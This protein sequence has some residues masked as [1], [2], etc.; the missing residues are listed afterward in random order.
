VV[1]ERLSDGRLLFIGE[2]DGT[3][4][5]AERL[6]APVPAVQHPRFPTPHSAIDM[7]DDEDML[8]AFELQEVLD[9]A[10][11]QC[12]TGR[13]RACMGLLNLAAQQQ[14]G[15]ASLGLPPEVLRAMCPLLAEATAEERQVLAA[16]ES[17]CAPSSE[18]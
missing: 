16:A 2:R 10:M 1:A 8:P 17:L 4:V 5:Q 18:P 3:L 14:E 9:E 12:A 11:V 7:P 6:T 15:P 13:E